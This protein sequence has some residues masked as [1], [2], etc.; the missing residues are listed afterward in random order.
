MLG[1]GLISVPTNAFGRAD[2]V[3]RAPGVLRDLGL[4]DALS[5]CTDYG[6]VPVLPSRPHRD[7]ATGIIDPAGPAAMRPLTQGVAPPSGVCCPPAGFAQPA[8]LRERV[9]GPA[10]SSVAVTRQKSV[11]DSSHVTRVSHAGDTNTVLPPHH[12]SVSTTR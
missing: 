11:F 6:D 3:A 5:P 1:F 4:V 10:V 8:N 2:G 9:R 7:A 12:F